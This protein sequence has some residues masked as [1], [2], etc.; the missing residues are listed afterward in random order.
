MYLPAYLVEPAGVFVDACRF[1]KPSDDSVCCLFNVHGVPISCPVDVNQPCGVS[2]SAC[3][4]RG[5]SKPSSR[6]RVWFRCIRPW[7]PAAPMPVV[8]CHSAVLA[9]AATMD[10]AV[11][12]GGRD[13]GGRAGCGGRG[14]CGGCGGFGGCGGCGDCGSRWPR[15]PLPSWRLRRLLQPWRPRRPR[16]P[17][18]SGGHGGRGG[19]GGRGGCSGR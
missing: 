19:R 3:T 16:C 1:V 9:A 2:V 8:P 13:G 4:G 6:A 15:R 17:R 10:T 7:H 11:A 5:A 12:R 14:G 18:G